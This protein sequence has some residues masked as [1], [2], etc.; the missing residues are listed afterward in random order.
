MK[1][2]ESSFNLPLSLCLGL[3]CYILMTCSFARSRYGAKKKLESNL[4]GGLVQLKAENRDL[5]FS[6]LSV[7]E[8]GEY[9]DRMV[10]FI[11]DKTPQVR[12]RAASP[13]RVR[14]AATLSAA[15]SYLGQGTG[16]PAPRERRGAATSL[17]PPPSS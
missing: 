15:A 16:R 11:R 6:A 4:R 7:T 8:P 10:A 12:T 17:P 14:G 13:V 1:A 3:L 2:S 5:E 9:A